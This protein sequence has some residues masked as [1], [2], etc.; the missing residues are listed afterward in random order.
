MIKPVN[1]KQSIDT[2]KELRRYWMAD[3]IPPSLD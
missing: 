1:L 2:V 3:V